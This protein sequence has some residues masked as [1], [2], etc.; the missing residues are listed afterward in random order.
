MAS[1][2]AIS[3]SNLGAMVRQLVGNLG[4]KYPENK[5]T[6][7]SHTQKKKERKKG[8]NQSSFWRE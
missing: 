1:V 3:V 2:L 7:H 6:R 4:G 5:I 8:H